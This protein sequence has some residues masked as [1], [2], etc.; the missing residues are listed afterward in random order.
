MKKLLKV[1]GITCAALVSVLL[2]LPLFVNVDKYRPEIESKMGEALNSKVKM[3]KLGLS[4]IPSIAVKTESLEVT[5][6]DI[7][8]PEAIVKCSDFKLSIPLLS[9]IFSPRVTLVLKKPEITVLEKNGKYNFETLMEKSAKPAETTKTAPSESGFIADKISSARLNLEVSDAQIRF[10]NT[11]GK[12]KVAIDELL[13][14]NLGFNAPIEAKLISNV[15]FEGEVGKFSGPFELKAKVDTEKSGDAIAA[16]FFMEGDFT[17][18][19]LQ[20]GATFKKVEKTPFRFQVTGQFKK[21][22]DIDLSVSDLK[23]ELASFVLGGKMQVTSLNNKESS[24]VDI[25]IH[26]QS[27]KIEELLELS[28]LLSD[29]KLKGSLAV[30]AKIKGLTKNPQLNIEVKA[31]NIKGQSPKLK[32]PIDEIKAHLKVSGSLEE[33]IIELDPADLLIGKS[34]IRVKMYATGLKAPNVKL[35]ITSK[36]L[37]LAFLNTGKE[38][39]ASDGAADDKAAK[40][41]DAKAFDATLDEMAPGLEKSLKNPMLDKAKVLFT[42]DIAELK[43]KTER[44]KNFLVKADLDSRNFK[45]QQ[46]SLSGYGGTVSFTGTSM[47]NPAAPTYD[48][49][50]KLVSIEL[51]KAIAAHAPAWKGQLSG[52]LKG[53]ARFQG[54]GLKKAQ[55]A[56]NLKGYLKGDILKGTT[57]LQLTKIVSSVMKQLPQKPDLKASASDEKLKGKFKTLKLDTKIQGRTIQ[58]ADLDIVY[59]P[60]EYKLGDLRFKGEGTLSF[61]KQLSMTGNVFLSPQ[62]VKFSEA[63]GPSGQVEIPVKVS[64][65]MNSPTPDIGYTISKMGSRVLKKTL[66][67]GVQKGID[68]LLKGKSPGDLFKGLFK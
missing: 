47:L 68:D 26:N 67:K 3:G 55:L 42:V 19:L 7:S 25:D 36:S 56:Q 54:Q 53:E 17:K 1:A 13:L 44:I 59:E 61:D 8:F 31:D 4:L 16:K 29:Y 18:M 6:N 32:L 34:D 10:E 39:A 51:A 40:A 11:Q 14:K 65:A 63:I 46:C 38:S 12:A 66:Q 22:S 60:D 50:L 35:S 9:L 41:E 23:F 20:A 49:T 27:S 37:D 57:S 58:L 2:V 33:P 21:A 15:N 5:P 24:T 43:L 48:Y 62:V 52:T 30:N 64:G 28:P 45:V